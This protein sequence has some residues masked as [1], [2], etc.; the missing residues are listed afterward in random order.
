V[1]PSLRCRYHGW[2]FRADGSLAKLPDG[3]SFRGW[4]AHDAC[5]AQFRVEKLGPLIFVNLSR[6]APTLREA[7]G[8]CYDELALQFAGMSLA[9]HQR[10]EHAANWKIAIENAVESYHVP[11]VH[12]E[13]FGD[14]LPEKF[15]HHELEAS[16]SRYRPTSPPSIRERLAFE[17]FR[18]MLRA[19]RAERYQHLH[20]FPNY[21]ITYSGIYRE[22]VS[23]LPLSADRCVREAYGFVPADVR[24]NPLSKALDLTHRSLLRRAAD[25]LLAED[26]SVWPFVHEGSRHSQQRGV[27]SSREERVYHFQRYVAG[28]LGRERADSNGAAMSSGT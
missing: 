16:F 10:T 28:R 8:P 20:V 11:R 26:A 4:K 3:A 25:R 18:W 13:S 19:D 23:V 5:L 17:G 14:Y 22:F 2:E 9:I 6:T 21:L 1:S 15:H 7:L 27:L 12:P 24:R